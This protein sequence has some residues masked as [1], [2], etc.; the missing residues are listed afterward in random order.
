MRL[1]PTVIIT[2]KKPW[3]Y[4]IT[5]QDRFRKRSVQPARYHGL[6]P[7]IGFGDEI[8]LRRL[9]PNLRRGEPAEPWHDLG[10]SRK[11][12]NGNIA[13]RKPTGSTPSC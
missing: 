7:L 4:I 5:N 9:P 3:L 12:K 1:Q 6:R 8:K 2:V 10:V 11:G 13:E